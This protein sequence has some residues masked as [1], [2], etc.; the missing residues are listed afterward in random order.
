MERSKKEKLQ[1]LLASLERVVVAF[2]GGADS[3]LLLAMALTVLGRDNVLAVTAD[4]PSLP[5]TELREAQ[6]LAQEM[7]ATH[8]IVRTEELKDERYAAILPIAATTARRSCSGSC[9]ESLKSVDFAIFSLARSRTI[10][11]S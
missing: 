9:G 8:L 6:A 3:T 10:W 1:C 7:G 5:R 11:T 4:S 2:S